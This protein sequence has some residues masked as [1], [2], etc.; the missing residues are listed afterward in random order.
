MKNIIVAFFEHCSVCSFIMQTDAQ[1]N[2]RNFEPTNYQPLDI[3]TSPELQTLLEHAVSETLEKFTR[4]KISKR[5][6]SPRH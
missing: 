6:M 5:K 2:D 1:T 4:R 3:E